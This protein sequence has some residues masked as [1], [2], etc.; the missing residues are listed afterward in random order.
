MVDETYPGGRV[1]EEV[2]RSV[3]RLADYLRDF[4][5]RLNFIADGLA[6]NDP[7]V[8]GAG[9]ALRD[10]EKSMWEL[11][12]DMEKLPAMARELAEMAEGK[13][14]LLPET[15]HEQELFN[16]LKAA[17]GMV[18]HLTPRRFIC[19]AGLKAFKTYKERYAEPYPH[20]EAVNAVVDATMETMPKSDGVESQ[21]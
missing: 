9:L 5:D 21:V 4:V 14:I 10:A 3:D 2:I 11:M 15:H 17:R 12:D 1:G 13:A 20:D 18:D 19:E 7:N 8:N 16:A 6:G